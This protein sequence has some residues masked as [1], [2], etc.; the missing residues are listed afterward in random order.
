MPEKDKLRQINDQLKREV[1][2]QRVNVSVT[3][4]ELLEYSTN[5]PDPLVD[6]IQKRDNPFITKSVCTIL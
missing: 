5:E 2:I 3:A 6:G 4:R 1:G